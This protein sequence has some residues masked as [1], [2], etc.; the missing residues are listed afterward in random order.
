MSTAF[1]SDLDTVLLKLT[2]KDVFTLRDACN[3]LHCFGS[4]GSG[5]TSGLGKSIA[6]AYLRAG[7]GGVVCIAK[8]EELTAWAMHVKTH[9]R[10]QD[11]LVFGEGEGINFLQYEFARAGADGA[12]RVTDTLMK[13]L[14]ASDR[15]AGQEAGKKGEEFWVKTSRQLLLYAVAALYGATGTVRMNDLIKFIDSAPVVK[16][17]TP[18]QKKSFEEN[19]Y[20]VSTLSKMQKRPVCEVAQDLREQSINYFLHQYPNLSPDTR[21]SVVLSVTATLNRFNSGMLRKA[22]CDKTTIVPEMTFGGKIILL[23]F[24]VLTTLEEGIVAQHLFSFLWMRAVEGR[25]ALPKQFSERP[26]FYYADE[27]QFFIQPYLDTFLSTCRGSKACVV[28]LTQSLPTYY[29]QLGKDKEAVV[30][31]FV[32][33]F[34]TKVFFLNSCPKTNKYASELV[35]KGIKIRKQHTQNITRAMNTNRGGSAAQT[36][37]GWTRSDTNQEGNT[38]QEHETYLLP[39]NYFA[40]QLRNGSPKNNFEVTGVLFKAGAQF[41]EPIP[42]TSSNVLLATFNQK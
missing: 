5:K 2:S 32:G 36:S 21:S 35:G 15:A 28:M 1:V 30:D 19:N 17:I 41:L 6:G 4:I 33:K 14:E 29:A 10:E 12:N 18:E 37:Q 26:V 34:N 16:P 39:S 38:T 7:M 8:P 11:L 31:G 42:E 9:G 24:P 27:S 20:T 13:I 25:N 23:N 40:T 3:G 22:F